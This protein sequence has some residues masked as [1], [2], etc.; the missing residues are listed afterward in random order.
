DGSAKGYVSNAHPWSTGPVS[1]LSKYVLGMRP[2][3]P[4]WTGWIVEPQ[5]GDLTFAQ[6]QV[7]TQTGTVISRWES[8]APRSFFHLTVQGNSTYPGVVAIPLF[9]VTNRAIWRD[10]VKVWENGTWLGG[11]TGTVSNDYV[12]FTIVSGTSGIH[13]YAW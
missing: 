7:Q 6:G 10:N 2:T 8:D 13:N 3:A 11:A 12:R 1:A 9:G 4:G 5:A